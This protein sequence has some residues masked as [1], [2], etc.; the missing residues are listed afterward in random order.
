M[1]HMPSGIQ[2]FLANLMSVRYV[3]HRLIINTIEELTDDAAN[4]EHLRKSRM[5]NLADFY[6]LYGAIDVHLGHDLDTADVAQKLVE[7]ATQVELERKRSAERLDPVDRTAATYHDYVRSA[8]NDAGPR[9]QRIKFL[10]GIIL[11]TT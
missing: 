6:G 10:S 7:F 8:S 4:G 5:R 3:R 9:A 1:P 2:A 11:E